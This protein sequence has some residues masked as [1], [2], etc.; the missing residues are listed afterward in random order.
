MVQYD[1][2]KTGKMVQHDGRK[3]MK[4]RKNGATRGEENIPAKRICRSQ[5]IC[6]APIKGSLAC[7][8]RS[9]Y[10]VSGITTLAAEL[11]CSHRR[12]CKHG[13]P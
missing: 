6:K 12:N 7:K 5:P 1:G 11:C 4:N 8:H 10:A 9:T 2:G 3:N 13:L